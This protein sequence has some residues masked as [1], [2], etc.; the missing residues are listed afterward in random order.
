[1]P[2]PFPGMDPYLE[3]YLWPDVHHRLADQISE[4]LAPRLRPRYVARLSIRVLADQPPEDEIRIMYPDVEV[5]RSR[6]LAETRAPVLTSAVTAPTLTAPLTIPVFETRVTSVEVRDVAQNELVAVIEI[7]SP[8]NKREPGL[9]RY[10][11]KRAEF[12]ETGVHLLEI[13]L[14][15]RG[16]RPWSVAQLRATSYVVALTR[17]FSNKMEAWP[18]RLQDPLPT[19]PVPL[20]APDPDVPLELSLAFSTI[21]D[22]AAYDLSIDYRQSPPPPPISP[23]D[24]DWVK[25]Q[26]SKG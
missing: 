20:R 26:A 7:L 16:T 1:M 22:R 18:L 9:T 2:S 8:V 5:V 23:E 14:L 21:Y 15:R 19:V 17:A 12:Y 3:G 4:L 13:D 11:Q 25:L 6:R 10:L 24:A